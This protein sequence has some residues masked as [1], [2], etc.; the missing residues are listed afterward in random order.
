MMP[1]QTSPLP[2]DTSWES[3]KNTISTAGIYWCALWSWTK[4]T[5]LPAYALCWCDWY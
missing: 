2:P 4:G 3:E 1:V 5:S